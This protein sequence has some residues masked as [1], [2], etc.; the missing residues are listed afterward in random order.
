MTQELVTGLGREALWMTLLVGAPILILGLVVGLLVGVFQA[1]TQI[2]EMTLAYVPKIIAVFL[3]ALVFGPWMMGLM[4][5]FTGR[6]LT[7]LPNFIR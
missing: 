5:D 7:N 4:L 1:A 3:G 2:N 6:L